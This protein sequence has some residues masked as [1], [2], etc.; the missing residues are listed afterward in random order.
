MTS[1]NRGLTVIE[2]LL[3][4]GI[5]LTIFY[6]RFSDGSLQVT[7]SSTLIIALGNLSRYRK[8]RSPEELRHFFRFTA[9]GSA[10]LWA[11]YAVIAIFRQ[12]TLFFFV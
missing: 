5:V 8:N 3:V 1:K 10:A 9:V 2:V 12:Y 6:F 4:I 11:V 7:I